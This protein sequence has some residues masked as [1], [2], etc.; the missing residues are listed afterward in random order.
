MSLKN[1]SKNPK[2]FTR[3]S[4]ERVG[5]TES[6]SVDVRVI[7]ATNKDLQEEIKNGNFEKICFIASM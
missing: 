1:P 2:D 5:G 6:I 7:A 4:F 3:Q